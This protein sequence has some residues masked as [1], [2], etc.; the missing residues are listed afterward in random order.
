[1]SDTVFY[2]IVLLIV[3]IPFF[4][5]YISHITG[6]DLNDKLQCGKCKI[7]SRKGIWD[8]CN[9]KIEDDSYF[10]KKCPVCEEMSEFEEV[11]IN[12]PLAPRLKLIQ[13]YKINKTINDNIA[14]NEADAQIASYLKIQEKRLYEMNKAIIKNKE[15]KYA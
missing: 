8:L 5:L 4:T 9:S 3:F 14:I 11:H 6:E 1:M 2:M 12:A 13:C 10:I 15:E 7:V